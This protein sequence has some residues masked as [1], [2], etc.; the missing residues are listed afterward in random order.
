MCDCQ[1]RCGCN[2]KVEI[3]MDASFLDKLKAAGF[4]NDRM[5]AFSNALSTALIVKF[6]E[7]KNQLFVKRSDSEEPSVLHFKFD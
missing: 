2:E 3:E 4:G 1:C 6:L 5:S 7:S